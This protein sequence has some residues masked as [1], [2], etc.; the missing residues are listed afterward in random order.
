MKW[1]YRLFSVI[2]L[3]GALSLPFYAD[4]QAGGDFLNIKEM[5]DKLMSAITPS[6]GGI[7]TDEPKGS[8]VNN[9]P[10]AKGSKEYYRW[11]DEHGQWHFSDEK[12]SNQKNVQSAQLKPEALQTI[13]GMDPSLINKT[14]QNDSSNLNTSP[15]LST[16]ESMTQPTLENMT[17]VMQNARDAA[18][19]MNER[20]RA[21]H[22]LVT[23]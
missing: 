21:L 13:S 3:V 19:L 10:E 2:I 15:A 18:Q 7:Y 12:P 11:Q 1:V 14:Y 6:S 16:S 9:A 22:Q 23:D 5:P 20:N 4:Y 8:Q 17:E